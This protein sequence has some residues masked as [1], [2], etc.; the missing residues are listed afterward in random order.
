MILQRGGWRANHLEGAASSPFHWTMPDVHGVHPSAPRDFKKM[1]AQPR[2]IAS[3]GF[4]SLPK[5]PGKSSQ[6]MGAALAKSRNAGVEL[7]RLD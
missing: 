7:A 6:C 3:V 1:L 2:K 5:P 4:R